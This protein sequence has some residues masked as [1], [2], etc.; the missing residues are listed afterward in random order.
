MSKLDDLLQ[1]DE[2][3][4]REIK[5]LILDLFKDCDYEPFT[6]VDEVYKL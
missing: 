5:K 1:A 3:L 4:K 6:F 2:E